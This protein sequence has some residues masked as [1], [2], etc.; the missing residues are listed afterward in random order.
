MALYD[1]TLNFVGYRRL[2]YAISLVVIV[3]G[4]VFLGVRGLNQGIDFTGGNLLQVR[5][6]QETDIGTV[7]QAVNDLAITG[8]RVQQAG[9]NEFIIRTAELSEEDNARLRSGLEEKIGAMEVLRNEKVGA[10]I[11]RE[12]TD[13]AFLALAIASVLMVLYITVRFEFWFA[14]AAIVAL[15]HDVL[16]TTGFFAITGI[17]VDSTFVAALLTVIGY[18]INDTIVVFDRIRENLKG[19]RKEQLGEIVNRSISQTLVRSINT[20]LTVMMA[21]VALLV[22]GGETTKVFA[23]AMLVGTITGTYSSICIAS[24]L[25]VEMRRRGAKTRAVPSRATAR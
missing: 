3:I 19:S 10:M 20:S 15:V 11:G 17:E 22:L 5:F 6:N 24:P 23:L 12:L 8:Q 25:W 2:W 16:V 14:L 21:L 18:S 9:P 13:K 1:R 7:R 4:L